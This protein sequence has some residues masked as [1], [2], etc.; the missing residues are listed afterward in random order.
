MV[1]VM[2]WKMLRYQSK[3]CFSDVCLYV[4]TKRKVVPDNVSLPGSSGSSG[5]S[6]LVV[7]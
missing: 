7:G 2:L 1:F 3:K 4:V 5:L 6:V